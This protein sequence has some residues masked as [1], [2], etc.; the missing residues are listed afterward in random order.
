MSVICKTG[1]FLSVPPTTTIPIKG[2]KSEPLILRPLL[3]LFPLSRELES[4]LLKK[5]PKKKKNLEKKKKKKKKTTKRWPLDDPNLSVSSS[6]P[7]PSL[8][9]ALT[10]PEISPSKL[11]KQS[12]SLKLMKQAGGWVSLKMEKVEVFLQLF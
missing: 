9:T 6:T 12:E 1:L 8:I 10:T 3:F 2:S 11:E 4:L 5:K 7:K